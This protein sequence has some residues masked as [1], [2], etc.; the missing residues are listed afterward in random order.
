MPS[1]TK[2]CRQMGWLRHV[3][4]VLSVII[5]VSFHLSL[6]V[7]LLHHVLTVLSIIIFVSFPLCLFA[8][9]S[10]HHSPS[11]LTTCVTPSQ[12]PSDLAWLEEGG[13]H[14]QLWFPQQMVR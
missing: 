1:Y 13:H 14:W 12:Q 11:Q 3:L 6:F 8:G 5:F 9:N 2:P 10:A 4:T 7:C